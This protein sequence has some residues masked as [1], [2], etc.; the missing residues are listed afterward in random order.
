[1]YSAQIRLRVKTESTLNK[2]DMFHNLLCEIFKKIGILIRVISKKTRV[3]IDVYTSS[4][5]QK[6]ISKRVDLAAFIPVPSGLMKF[7][8]YF[9]FAMFSMGA[10]IKHIINTI[11]SLNN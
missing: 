6:M 8:Y 5:Q 9:Y 7:C 1:M 10:I 2:N 3:C 11:Y 4:N